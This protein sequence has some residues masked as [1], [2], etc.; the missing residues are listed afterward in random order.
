MKLYNALTQN[1]ETFTPLRQAV[2]IYVCG[3]TPYDTT[4][5][6]HAFT[7][8]A[9]DILI[10][11]LEQQG[12]PVRYAQNVTDIDDDILRKSQEVGEAW[13]S[14]GNRWTA[15]FIE[16][17]K[18]L[19]VRPPDY[20]PRATDVI[21]DI[22]ATVQKLLAAG[23]AYESGG[24]VYFYIN[25]WPQYGQ[26]SRLDCDEM[27]PI[28]NERGNKPDDPHKRDPMDFVLWQA[29]AP[30]EP[31]WESPWGLGRPGWHIECST[32]STRFLGDTIDIHGGGGD[33]IFPHHESEIAQ[34]E[35]LIADPAKTPFTRFWLHTA[36]V[37]HDGE[38]M[39]KSLGNLVMVRDLLRTW[40]SDALRLYMGNHHY[41]EIWSH[42]ETELKQA[43]ALA[44]K[45]RAA[46]A[47]SGG[48]GET[49]NPIA[50]QTTFDEAMAND[51]NTS[52]ALSALENL[53]D[54]ILAANSQNV[55][56]A[57]QALRQM[58]HIF[59]LRLDATEPEPRVTTG[60]NEHL[61]RFR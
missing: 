53:A 58:S 32:M 42:N 37:H 20:F 46:V 30:D 12:Y 21:G 25:S 39:S 27:L 40:S 23:V 18:N 4:H 1:I 2:T 43:A 33:L 17:M 60:W 28:A 8:A 10:R 24:N 35:P 3:I 9:F 54:K 26:L 41:R 59:G 50:A 11:Y 31:A 48:Q 36:M 19:N 14:L 7:Y 51:L 56:A 61:K 47:V 45:L 29:Q 34:A 15:H 49:L 13:D 52:A 5:L 16:D 6:G 44:Q 38:K 57:Q 22:I 55:T